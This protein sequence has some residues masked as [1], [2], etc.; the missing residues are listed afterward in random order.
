MRF[1]DTNIL[2]YAVSLAVEDTAK[3][4]L[5]VLILSGGELALSAQVLQEFYVQAT[6]PSRSGVLT[7]QEAVEFCESMTRFPIFPVDF[8]VVRE[9]LDI[10]SRFGLSYWDSAI[11]AAVRLAECEA[12]YSEDLSHTQDYDGVQVVNPF[13]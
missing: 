13:A 10:R 2:I 5:A 8:V 9:A 4:N 11:L 1:L 3:R 12:V 6:R 7:H